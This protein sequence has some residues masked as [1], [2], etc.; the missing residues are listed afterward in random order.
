MDNP[1]HGKSREQF[2]KERNLEDIGYWKSRI[3]D[4]GFAVKVVT[5]IGTTEEFLVDP[6]YFKINVQEDKETILNMLE[7]IITKEAVK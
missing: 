7:Q 5:R 6:Y 3:K 4:V 2:S 1:L